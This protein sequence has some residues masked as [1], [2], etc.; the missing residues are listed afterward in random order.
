MTTTKGLIK[1]GQFEGSVKVIST[2]IGTLITLGT[3]FGVW[4]NNHDKRI[5]EMVEKT[6]TEVV[7]VKQQEQFQKD[8]YDFRNK[9]ILA[10]HQQDSILKAHGVK[11]DKESIV[12]SNLRTY[13]MNKAATK[14]DLMSVV[15]VFEEVKKNY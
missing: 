5:L 8:M 14:D 2:I 9:T 13:M 15:N 1:I 10:L 4:I 12:M 6:R 7:N 3:A 11:I